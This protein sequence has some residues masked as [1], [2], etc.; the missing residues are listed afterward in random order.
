[1]PQDDVDR[2]K[3]MTMDKAELEKR[4]AVDP[5]LQ[6]NGSDLVA[7]ISDKIEAERAAKAEAGKLFSSQ[8]EE[9]PPNYRQ[10]VNKYFEALSQV[11]PAPAPAGNNPA[12]AGQF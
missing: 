2:L 10:F 6:R 12:P 3:E 7:R 8:R 4:L 1:V 11:A 9:C 5:K